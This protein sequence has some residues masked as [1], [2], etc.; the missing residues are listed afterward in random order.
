MHDDLVVFAQ[1]PEVGAGLFGQRYVDENYERG[2]REHRFYTA[3]RVL[4][5]RHQKAWMTYIQI[6]ILPQMLASVPAPS[7][8]RRRDMERYL[9]DALLEQGL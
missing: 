7:A 3:F 2:S 1:F 5:D 6:S 8:K 4:F 9:R